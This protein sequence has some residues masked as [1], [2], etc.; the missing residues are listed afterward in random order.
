MAEFT[1]HDINKY[2]I[3]KDN[4]K[5]LKIIRIPP[6][7]LPQ[8]R[9][10]AYGRETGQGVSIICLSE[11]IFKALYFVLKSIYTALKTIYHINIKKYLL[12]KYYK[13]LSY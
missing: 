13:L 11:K 9:V 8:K 4:T 1:K 12:F 5:Y 10:G 7:A 6:L 2:L 3:F